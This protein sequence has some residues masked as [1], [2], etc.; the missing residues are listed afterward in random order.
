MSWVRANL[1]VGADG[2]TAQGGSSKALSSGSDRARFHAI[3]SEAEAILI[4]GATARHEPYAATP[5]PLFVVSHQSSLPAG[6]ANNPHAHLLHL[7]PALAVAEIKASFNFHRIL[8]EGGAHL[9][10]ALAHAHLLDGLYLT[11]TAAEPN[12]AI[13]DFH[14]LLAGFVLVSREELSAE[15]FEY[16]ERG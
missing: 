1:V 11:R 5:C 2:S 14:E 3:R 9:V 12:E 10:T 7:S 16:Y 4:G 13:I 15:S 8:V 6:A